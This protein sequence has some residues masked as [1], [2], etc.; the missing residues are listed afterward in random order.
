MFLAATRW[1]A[2]CMRDAAE[3]GTNEWKMNLLQSLLQ[4][5]QLRRQ[6]QQR[7]AEQQQHREKAENTLT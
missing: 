3:R 4:K 6:Q 7:A 2:C 1:A 5:G